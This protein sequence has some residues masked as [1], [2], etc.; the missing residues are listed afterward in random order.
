MEDYQAQLSIIYH[1]PS[2]DGGR[3]N[4][5]DAAANMIAFSEFV[6]HAGHAVFGSATQVKAEVSGLRKG[7]F[8]TDLYFQ[9]VGPAATLLSSA[10]ASEW[11]KTVKTAFE[12]WKFLKGEPPQNTRGSGDLISV[13]NRDGVVQVF[14]RTTVNVV[15]D[16]KSGEA[17]QRF[18]AK[19]LGQE[20]VDKLTITASGEEIA[21]VNPNEAFFFRPVAPETPVTKNEFEYALTIEAPV[22]KDGNMWRFSDG[23]SSFAA[24]IE[25]KEFLQRVDAGEPFAKGDA[26]RVRL[27]VEQ[28]RQV[29]ELQ[30][31][32]S[33]VKVLEHLQRHKQ[34]P[35][36]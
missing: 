4:V 20:G 19:Q 3:I 14:N 22:F 15:F 6:T 33:V 1:G 23:G 30:T 10:S 32:R 21:S 11:I 2:V 26:L 7:S 35:L 34:Q 13:T 24:H 36:L 18:V 17:V 8:V 12:L 31:R 25:D 5:Y 29:Q 27:L 16:N 9:I 28:I